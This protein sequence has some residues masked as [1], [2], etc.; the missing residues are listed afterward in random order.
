MKKINKIKLPDKPGVYFFLGPPKRSEGGKKS[1]DILYIGKAT[2]LRDRTKSYFSKDLMDTRGPILADMLFYA[3]KIDYQ[4]TD[5]VL[6]AIILEANLIKKHQP[7][8]NTKEKSDKSFNYVV[9]TK[10]KLPKVLIVRGKELQSLASSNFSSFFGPYTSGPQLREAIK[11]I[12][13]I[14]PFLDEKSK[15]YMEFYKQINLVPDLNDRQLYLQNIKNIK[16]FF[17]GKKKQILRNLKKEMNAYSKL[18]EFE[19]AGEVKRQIFALQHINDIALIQ[20]SLQP[21]S[22]NLQ[23]NFRIEAYDIAHMGGKNMVGV[24]TVIEDGEA[25]K[26]EYRK[27]RIRTQDNANDT[28]ALKEILERRL[29]H[30]EWIYPDLVVIDGGIAQM[31]TA[32]KIIHRLNLC[33]SVVSVV[34]DERHKPKA[35]MGDEK[36]AVKYKREILLAN[37]EAHRFAISYHKKMRNKNFLSI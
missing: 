27:F 31:N 23:A 6:E 1:R 25:N 28:G 11:I 34:K 2:S 19:K 32:L 37:S 15:N 33:I 20:S 30:S 14:F 21:T 3:D 13:R 9:I 16:L 24:M 12:R 7:K 8:Y 22:Y 36:I 4:V 17:E 29:A 26:N 18:R 5:S 35:I 10:E